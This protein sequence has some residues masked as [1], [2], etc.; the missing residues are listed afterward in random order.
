MFMEYHDL[1]FNHI[2]SLDVVTKLC[3]YHKMQVSSHY[4]PIPQQ[5]SMCF[6]T[7]QKLHHVRLFQSHKAIESWLSH[8]LWSWRQFP[9]LSKI[10]PF[11]YNNKI[12]FHSS[13]IR[14]K[15]NKIDIHSLSDWTINIVV[16]ETLKLYTK[17]IKHIR[18]F[19]T[20]N[21]QHGFLVKNI[22]WKFISLC[23]LLVLFEF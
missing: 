2:L 1:I 18:L 16:K 5:N 7:M 20:I 10:F 23:L 19:L 8:K 11:S 22:S 4:R 9:Y 13:Y 12:S 15:N 14:S 21:I 3:H 6:Q 17:P